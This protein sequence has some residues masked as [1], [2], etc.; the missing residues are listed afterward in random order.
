MAGSRVEGEVLGIVASRMWSPQAQDAPNSCLKHIVNAAIRLAFNARQTRSHSA[1]TFS[2][3]R[4]LKRRKP[5]ISL[6]H[7]L[8]ASESHL[9]FAYRPRPSVLAS[10]SPM[11]L[12][13]RKR[14]RIDVHPF[15]ALP[16]Q[17]HVTIDATFLKRG[18]VLLVAVARV[19]QNRTGLDPECLLHPIQQREHKALIGGR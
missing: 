6:I 15:L 8:G 1:R 2:R 9:R 12:R 3:P 10:F 13:R 16:P 4:K 14:L 7:P 5:N 11:R 19:R 18:Q 17:R